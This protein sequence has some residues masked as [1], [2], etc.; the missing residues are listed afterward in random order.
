MFVSDPKRAE[1]NFELANK[2]TKIIN[3]DRIDLKVVNRVAH[4][5]LVK[6]YNRLNLLALAVFVVLVFLQSI[7]LRNATLLQQKESELQLKQLISDI[8]LEVNSLGHDF[9]HSKDH[10][11]L[12]DVSVDAVEK[13]IQAVLEENDIQIATY[14]SIFKETDKTIFISNKEEYKAKLLGTEI[15]SCLSCIMSFSMVSKEESTRQPDESQ[16]DFEKRLHK[17]STFQYF[18][19]VQNL[20]KDE[21]LWLTLY[22]P[23]SFSNALRSM[24]FLN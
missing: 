1:K 4:N 14:F 24:T 16:E 2:A 7:W 9:F 17:V 21:Q 10:L 12:K 6:Y 22:Q 20:V 19:P 8:A 23:F 18:S 13:K 15:K 11:R 5:Q 3:N